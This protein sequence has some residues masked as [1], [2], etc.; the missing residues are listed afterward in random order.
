MNV[1]RRTKIAS[2]VNNHKI[3]DLIDRENKFFNVERYVFMQFI[4]IF[5]VIGLHYAHLTRPLIDCN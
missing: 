3:F 2:A 5:F 4:I 1:L